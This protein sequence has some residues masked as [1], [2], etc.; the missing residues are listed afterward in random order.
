MFPPDVTRQI[1]TQRTRDTLTAARRR[2]LL[3]PRPVARST[4]Q[5]DPAPQPPIR[6]RVR[7]G[8]PHPRG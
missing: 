7:W 8:I 3:G 6:E 2:H 4:T 1:A 5:I